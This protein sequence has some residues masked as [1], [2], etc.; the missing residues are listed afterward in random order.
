MP[1]REINHEENPIL[2]GRVLIT[3]KE[4]HNACKKAYG[5]DQS[6]VDSYN[7]LLKTGAKPT[8]MDDSM[9]KYYQIKEG[10]IPVKDE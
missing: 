2:D 10:Q 3:E 8:L 9:Q 6:P 1:L 7:E 4:F 5:K